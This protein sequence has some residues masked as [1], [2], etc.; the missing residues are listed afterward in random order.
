[1]LHAES[2]I[3]QQVKTEMLQI[4]FTAEVDKSKFLK[5]PK[6]VSSNILPIQ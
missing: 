1:M 2:Y 6:I 3:S 5:Q 4:N